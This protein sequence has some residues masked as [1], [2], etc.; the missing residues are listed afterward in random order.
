MKILETIKEEIVSRIYKDNVNFLLNEM[1]KVGI[2]KLPYSYASL[3]PFIDEK[4]MNI[5][6]NKHYI[7]YVN[8]LN[9]A[10]K[11]NK[12]N[13][14]LKQIISNISKFNKTIRNNAGGAFNHALFW[15]MLSPAKKNIPKELKDKIIKSFGSIN[16]FKTKFEEK[17]KSHFGS[18][19]VWLV[20]TK[21]NTLKIITTPNQDN[22]LM[23]VIKGGGFPILGLDL[24]EHAYYLKYQNKRDEYIHNFW[25]YI[26]WDFV[27]ELYD[28]AN[29]NE[30]KE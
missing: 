5:H 15:N 26:N 11:N 2:E 30:P 1:K 23:N 27:L 8:K 25:N 14:D 3:K 21:N 29:N 16:S 19:W 12:S 28:N 7:G 24:W 17:A 9:K 13:Y 6:Y 10:L 18:G 20:A 22:P 4:T